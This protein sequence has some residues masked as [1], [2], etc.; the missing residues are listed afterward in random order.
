MADRIYLFE[1]GSIIEQGSHEEL[2][3]HNGRYREMFD[4]QAKNYIS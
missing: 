1:H 4:R 2:M 3:A